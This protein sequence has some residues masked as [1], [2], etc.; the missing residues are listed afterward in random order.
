MTYEETVRAYVSLI[1]RFLAEEIDGEL[2]AD[3]FLVARRREG[4]RQD[5]ISQSWPR[6]FDLELKEAVLRGAITGEEFERRYKELW[7]PEVFGEFAEAVG[8][9]FSGVVEYSP[10]PEVRRLLMEGYDEAGLR[11]YVQE[12]VSESNELRKLLHNL[13]T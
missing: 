7:G 13:D 4:D 6:R 2:F 5:Q 11:S 8:K 12:V 3:G 1:R 9:I 10:D